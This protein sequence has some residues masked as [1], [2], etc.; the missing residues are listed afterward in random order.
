M[1]ASE[2]F[3]YTCLIKL[4]AIPAVFA[5]PIFSVLVYLIRWSCGKV[6]ELA[7]PA[8]TRPYTSYT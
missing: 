6:L 3:Y 2:G 7:I 8:F 1:L 5:V 4:L